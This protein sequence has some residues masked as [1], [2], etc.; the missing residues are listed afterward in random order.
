MVLDISAQPA[1]AYFLEADPLRESRGG[2]RGTRLIGAGGEVE[3]RYVG[4]G[5]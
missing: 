5:S 3:L 2:N 4:D 1:L